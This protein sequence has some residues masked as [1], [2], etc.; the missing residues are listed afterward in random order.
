MVSLPLSGLRVTE[1]ASFVAGP[2]GAL[3]WLCSEPT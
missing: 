2:S 1:S 3:P